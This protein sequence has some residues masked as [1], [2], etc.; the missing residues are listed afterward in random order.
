[1]VNAELLPMKRMLESLYLKETDERKRIRYLN[2]IADIHEDMGNETLS[3]YCL[4]ESLSRDPEQDRFIAKIERIN[5]KRDVPPAPELQEDRCDVSVIIPTRNRASEL[6]VS[7]QS[8]LDQEYG[9]YEIIVVDDAG[10]DETEEV[11]KSFGSEK[12]LYLK[13][14]RNMGPSRARNEGI[15]RAGGRYIAYLDD[16]D[17]YYPG[18]LALLAG[19]LEKHPSMDAVYSNSWWVYGNLDGRTFVPKRRTLLD[20]RP[21]EFD[22]DLLCRHNWIVPMNLMH[23][24]SVFS[25]AGLFNEDLS[26]FEDWDLFLRFSMRAKFAQ[27]N[28]ITGEYR[29]K[30]NNASVVGNRE[31]VFLYPVIRRYYALYFGNVALAGACLRRNDRE[32]AMAYMKEIQRCHEAYFRTGELYDSLVDLFEMIGAGPLRREVASRIGRPESGDPS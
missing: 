20:R 28:D 9:N 4:C 14:E 24:K 19:Y 5:K 3:L 7:V 15:L 30:E 31:M 26:K 2:S 23:K 13:L 8:V 11:L 12:I 6:R 21:E 10:T 18:H 25:R 1:M 29:W 22:R 32:K 27:L 17:V 16:D